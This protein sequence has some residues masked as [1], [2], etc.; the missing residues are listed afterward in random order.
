MR[1]HDRATVEYAASVMTTEA[2]TVALMLYVDAGETSGTWP[3][4]MSA[5]LASR[6]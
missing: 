6:P 3:E 2:L 1:E 5:E 4:V